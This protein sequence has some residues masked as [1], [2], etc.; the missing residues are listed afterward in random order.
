MGQSEYLWNRI[1]VE[2]LLAIPKGPAI[3]NTFPSW[4]ILI[5]RHVFI[6][7]LMARFFCINGTQRYCPER[8]R[9]LG[10]RRLKKFQGCFFF[11]FFFIYIK[12]LFLGLNFAKVLYFAAFRFLTRF[13]KLYILDILRMNIYMLIK[14][15][16]TRTW[17]SW[18]VGFRHPA[19]ISVLLIRAFVT[20][21]RLLIKYVSG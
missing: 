13:V 8:M 3:P 5:I 15:L 7:S 14:S 6:C 1:Y 4:Q 11:F 18:V 12:F 19:Q 21:P 2:G 17:Y 10:K 16:A 9:G 20:K